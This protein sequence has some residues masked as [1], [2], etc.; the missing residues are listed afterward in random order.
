MKDDYKNGPKTCVHCGAPVAENMLF[1]ACRK[2]LFSEC[3]EPLPD[4]KPQSFASGQ[5]RL[6]GNYELLNQIG[7]GGMGVV[8]QARHC[9]LN[10]IV[11]LKML[12]DSG[13]SSRA[14]MERLQIEAETVARLDHPHI[15]PIYDFGEH[16]GHPFFTMRLIRGGSLAETIARSDFQKR[17]P[18]ERS[19]RIAELMRKT[20]EAVHYAHQHGVLHRDLKPSNILI[21]KAGE[22]HLV[23]FGLAKALDNPWSRDSTPGAII[24]TLAYMAPEQADARPVGIPAD[25][26]SLGSILYHLLTGRPPFQAATPFEAF[27]KL[28]EEDVTPPQFI[29]ADADRDL[30]IICLKC[31]DKDP[32]RRYLSAAALAED[33]QRRLDNRPI[34]GR[35][36][37]AILRTRRWAQ[38]NRTV[39]ALIT[40]LVTALIVTLFSLKQTMDA[41]STR[42][43]ALTA[44]QRILGTAID[45]LD[46]P[47]PSMFEINSDQLRVI[48]GRKVPPQSPNAKQFTAGVFI[49]S[50]PTETVLGYAEMLAFLEEKVSQYLHQPVCINLRLYLDYNVAREDLVAG[51]VHFARIDPALFVS[52]ANRTNIHLLVQEQQ[53]DYPAHIFVRA[54]SGITNMAGLQGKDIVFWDFD[55]TTALAAKA[56]LYRSGL[57]RASLSLHACFTNAGVNP[58]N[59]SP[60]SGFLTRQGATVSAVLNDEEYEAGVAMG[61]QFRTYPSSAWRA[62]A[63]FQPQRNIWAASPGLDPKFVESLRQA[64]CDWLPSD[65][66]RKSDNWGFGYETRL[67][68]PEDQNC[69]AMRQIIEDAAKFDRCRPADF[70]SSTDN[71]AI[72]SLTD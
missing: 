29:V 36:A 54:G 55:S 53:K 71:T 39:T 23:D 32:Q 59:E 26:Y 5:S 43:R 16:E 50:N 4:R 61:R 62:L 67:V 1:G 10:R 72:N 8:Y 46:K 15:V 3:F 52:C 45:R 19:R 33:L 47:P 49:G 60:H 12:L 51:R 31:L 17:E 57:C 21:D 66:F 2:C 30:S 11:A 63:T 20:A 68:S 48:S 70:D 41:E 25:I 24:G 40:T 13:H 58:F 18:R 44:L 22:P 9:T 14:A 37:S 65:N 7:R 27:R 42:K 34:M 64:F 56:T 28:K 69:A 35:P 38:R 6:F